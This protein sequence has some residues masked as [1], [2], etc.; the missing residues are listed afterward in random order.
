MNIWAGDGEPLARL[1]WRDG[2]VSI[3]SATD[4]MSRAAERWKRSGLAEWLRRED[5]AEP[6]VTA[7]SS[8]LFLP[9]LAMYLERQFSL[10]V[11][12]EYPDEIPAADHSRLLQPW[13]TAQ[14]PRPESHVAVTTMKSGPNAL[15]NVSVA[16]PAERGESTEPLEVST[17][18]SGPASILAAQAP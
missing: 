12:L 1:S 16:G 5:A 7:S 11:G 9:R 4:R 18:M 8:P 13:Q 6:R 2:V 10:G 17:A 14:L 3:V 15:V